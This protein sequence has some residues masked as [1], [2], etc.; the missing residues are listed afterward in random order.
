MNAR[1]EILAFSLLIVI[2]LIASAC[3]SAAT[4]APQALYDTSRG[5]AGELAAAAPTTAPEPTAAP[6]DIASTDKSGGGSL[7]VSPYRANRL[8]IKN[9]E[10]NLLVVDTSR[11]IDQVTDIAVNG[12]G[13]IVSSRTWSD[14]A[15][16]FATL[17]L[18]VPVE[19]FEAVQRQLRALAVTVL[20]D[21]ASG[22]DVSEEYV[23]LQ[24]RLTNLE[25]TAAR[26]REFLAQAK[27]VD[28]ALQVNARL[29][30][31]ENEIEQIKG[32]MNYLKDRAAF[33]TIVVNL[34]PQRPT[35]TPTPTATPAAWTPEKTFNAAAGTLSGVLRSLGDLLIWFGVVVAPF[36]VPAAIV[37]AVVTRGRRKNGKRDA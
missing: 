7:G 22:Q 3:A 17:T 28:E 26:I 1:R 36:A 9:G 23:D 35:P 11:A 31:V 19:Q 24:S 25:A 14:D 10:M 33:S 32:R 12:G 6:V 13:Y 37:G 4:P 18:G 34:E 16:K 15:F 5:G 21:T 20:N 27:D 29:T 30:D 8:I 2:G